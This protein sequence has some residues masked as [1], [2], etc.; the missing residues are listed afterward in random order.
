MRA[1]ATAVTVILLKS[2]QER[3]G[4]MEPSALAACRAEDGTG[5]RELIGGMAGALVDRGKG[6]PVVCGRGGVEWVFGRGR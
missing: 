1:G 5:A 3:V 2:D 6:M 4:V